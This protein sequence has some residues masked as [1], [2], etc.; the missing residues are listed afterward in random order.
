MTTSS[1]KTNQP[2]ITENQVSATSYGKGMA[3]EASNGRTMAIMTGNKDPHEMTL[4]ELENELEKPPEETP[5]K[6][7]QTAYVDRMDNLTT[8]ASDFIAETLRNLTFERFDEIT[9]ETINRDEVPE[10]EVRL[11]HS[12]ITNA[13]ITI[14]EPSHIERLREETGRTK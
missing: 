2:N 1:Q 7:M 12:M 3:R 9:R 11:I 4:A 10:A 13:I 14:P 8:L 5:I 6:A